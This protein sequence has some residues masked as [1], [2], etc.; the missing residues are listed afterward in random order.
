[1]KNNKSIDLILINL[2]FIN[3]YFQS[4]NKCLEKI[5]VYSL[6]SDTSIITETH[7]KDIT[8]IYPILQSLFICKNNSIKETKPSLS[9]KIKSYSPNNTSL[10]K[11][12]SNHFLFLVPLVLFS[13]STGDMK[14]KDKSRKEPLQLNTQF[15][16]Y[17][18]NYF[19]ILTFSIFIYNIIQIFA[20]I[21]S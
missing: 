17:L 14:E 12:T 1:M 21:N 3:I 19:I 5:L 11:K 8:K 18:T 7:G 16:V 4:N 10:M 15:D 9:I 13:I 2:S 20:I 6:P